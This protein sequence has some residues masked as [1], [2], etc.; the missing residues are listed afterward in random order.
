MKAKHLVYLVII[1]LVLRV[2][3]NLV[4]P[5]IAINTEID[6]LTFGFIGGGINIL[7]FLSIVG[8][9]MKIFRYHNIKD[10]LNN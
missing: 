7:V 2:G 9:L 5:I 4:M 3:L 1:G 10:F 8:L 6:P